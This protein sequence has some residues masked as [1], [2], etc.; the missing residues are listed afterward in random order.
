ML[1]YLREVFHP[2]KSILIHE[3]AMLHVQEVH[4][5]LQVRDRVGVKTVK[6]I[7]RKLHD[8]IHVFMSENIPFTVKYIFSFEIFNFNSEKL[9]KN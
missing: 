4:L 8:R 3:P 1:G 2:G 7:K 6:R 9:S 5:K